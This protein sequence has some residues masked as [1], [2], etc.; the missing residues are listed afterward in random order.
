MVFFGY[1]DSPLP[2][3]AMFTTPTFDPVF[4]WVSVVVSSWVFYAWFF[5]PAQW[6][7]KRSW[8]LLANLGKSSIIESQ[9]EVR[10]AVD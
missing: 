6:G 5:H 7:A 8:P 1:K 9:F 10:S 2:T 4:S 3:S